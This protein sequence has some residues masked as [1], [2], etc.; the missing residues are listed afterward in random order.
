VKLINLQQDLECGAL[1]TELYME[2]EL[3]EDY[4]VLRATTNLSSFTAAAYVGLLHDQEPLTD[5]V[6]D[7][8]SLSILEGL[9]LPKG[10]LVVSGFYTGFTPPACMHEQRI[11]FHLILACSKI[12]IRDP[13]LTAARDLI[14]PQRT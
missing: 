5:G 3:D 6:I 4:L 12:G 9:V 10:K 14:P 2:R 1:G 7:A 8:S 11:R 13:I